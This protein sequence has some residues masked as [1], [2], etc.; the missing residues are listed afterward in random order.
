MSKT[1]VLYESR[2]GFTKEIAKEAALVLGP[3]VC[4]HVDKLNKDIN[5]FDVIVVCTPVYNE[6][7]PQN[8]MD[9]VINNAKLIK[10]K[11]VVLF[12]SFLDIDSGIKHLKPIR[13]ILGSSVIWQEIVG[14]KVEISHLKSNDYNDLE[15]LC[16]I[17]EKPFN[18]KNFFHKEKFLDRLLK[19]RSIISG[20]K[21]NIGR[22]DGMKYVESFLNSHSTCTLG[23]GYLFSVRATPMNYIYKD[24]CI[25]MVSEFGD[26]FYNILQNPNVSVAVYDNTTD[27]K[28]LGGMQIQ[29]IATIIDS[30]TDEYSNILKSCKWPLIDKED[31]TVNV[32]KVEI[33]RIEFVWHEFE[34]MGYDIKQCF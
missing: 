6:L 12:C 26:K 24:G 16:E 17:E 5:I 23:T 18:D 28:Q 22:E 19:I 21:P 29:G 27:Y 20:K 2:H 3:S 34:K 9:F 13:D 32:I 15:K 31:I 33:S 1:L 11:K 30:E 8:I 14:A 4:S 7:L 10:K 25:Y